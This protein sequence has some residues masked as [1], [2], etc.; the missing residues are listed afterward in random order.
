VVIVPT[1]V[2][3]GTAGQEVYRHA[4]VF[5]EEVLIQKLRDLKFIG[6]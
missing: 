6:D 5:K 4:G 3:L 2:C 1:Q